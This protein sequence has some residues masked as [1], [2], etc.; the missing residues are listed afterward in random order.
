[1]TIQQALTTLTD[2]C[3]IYFEGLLISKEWI[4]KKY[5]E[6][7]AS[8]LSEGERTVRIALHTGSVCFDM[9]AY[10]VAALV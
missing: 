8:S 2:K 9:L 7:F 5:I 1:V 6:F 4:L 3:E 10:I